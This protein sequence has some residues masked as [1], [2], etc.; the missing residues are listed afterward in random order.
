MGILCNNWPLDGSQKTFRAKPK[1]IYRVIG[2]N[3]NGKKTRQRGKRQRVK[4]EKNIL[5]KNK[6]K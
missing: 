1:P 6:L 4:M 5:C 3:D 2:S